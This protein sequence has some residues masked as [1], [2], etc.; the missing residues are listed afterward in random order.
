MNE[1]IQKIENINNNLEFV[2]SKVQFPQLY[3]LEDT[4][5]ELLKLTEEHLKLKREAEVVTEINSQK[6][7]IYRQFSEYIETLEKPISHP[8]SKF[9]GLS[10][11]MFYIAPLIDI[12]N[13]L[14]LNLKGISGAIVNTTADPKDAVDDKDDFVILLKQKRNDIFN[15]RNLYDLYLVFKSFSEDLKKFR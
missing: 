8:F 4:E 5:A 15:A 1:L 3:K 6:E 13:I 12:R 7:L 9:Q 10:F 2:R 14:F 11:P